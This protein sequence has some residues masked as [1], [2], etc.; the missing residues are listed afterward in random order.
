M[1]SWHRYA[2]RASVSVVDGK[3]IL[4]P[5]PWGRTAVPPEWVGYLSRPLE[6][7]LSQRR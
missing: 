4:G 5:L 1:S 3:A 6:A 2:P 7:G